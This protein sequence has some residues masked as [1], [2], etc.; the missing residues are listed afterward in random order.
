[1]AK[2]TK[3]GL[4]GH[5]SL[6]TGSEGTEAAPAPDYEVVG[7]VKSDHM[8][9]NFEGQTYDLA[10]LSPDQAAYLLGFPEQVPYLRPLAQ[11]TT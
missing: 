6:Q 10:N 3:T 5:E 1:M 4:D 2:T 7:L 9:V 11:P 8:P